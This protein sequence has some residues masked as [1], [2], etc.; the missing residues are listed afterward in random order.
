MFGI[1][2]QVSKEWKSRLANVA[3][4]NQYA[5]HHSVEFKDAVLENFS[6]VGARF[7]GAKFLR[8]NWSE[9]DFKDSLVEDSLFDGG[10]YRGISFGGSVLR[11]VTFKNIT[12]YSADFGQAELDNV[13][14]IKCNFGGAK[15][16][17]LEKSR[18]EFVDSVLEEVRFYDS[19]V[20]VRYVDSKLTEV[21]M[22]GTTAQDYFVIKSSDVYDLNL[23]DS[24]LPYVEVS[25]STIKKMSYHGGKSKK[26][27]MKNLKG[28]IQASGLYADE[29]DIEN[30]VTDV[31]ILDGLQ[32]KSVKISKV[33]ATSD[34]HLGSEADSVE[35]E[36]SDIYQ[37]WNGGSKVGFYSIKN[38]KLGGESTTSSKFGKLHFENVT[39]VE[40]ANFEYTQADEVE[41]HNVTKGPNFEFLG[42]G[43]NVKF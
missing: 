6:L 32:G 22:M 37:L 15:F 43:S 31:L 36:D 5:E 33:N 8:T 20:D 7:S 24:K 29:V 38:T 19:D 18:I 14:F 34:V 27:V 16:H 21:G 42:E 17:G 39:I 25:D 23:E 35:I 28:A 40:G 1:K 26:L 12:F 2:A 4:F 9:A 10:D 11:N 13:K 41:I 3:E 30:V